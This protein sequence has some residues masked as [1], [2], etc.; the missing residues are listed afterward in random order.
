VI[1]FRRGR[2]TFGCK[3]RPLRFQLFAGVG[4]LRAVM[5]QLRAFS[6]G[7]LFELPRLIF[8]EFLLPGGNAAFVGFCFFVFEVPAGGDN[9]RDRETEFEFPSEDRD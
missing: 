1:E 6:G 8:E 7:F 9:E 5:G 2:S 3:C 4:E